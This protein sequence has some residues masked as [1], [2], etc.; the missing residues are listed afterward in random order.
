MLLSLRIYLFFR[1]S[2][3]FKSEMNNASTRSPFWFFANNFLRLSLL[4][5][6]CHAFMKACFLEEWQ[7]SLHILFLDFLS[8]SCFSCSSQ[9]VVTYAAL[10]V[11]YT[12]QSIVSPTPTPTRTRPFVPTPRYGA[13]RPNPHADQDLIPTPTP[14]PSP[15]PT[16]GFVEH[17]GSEFPIVPPSMDRCTSNRK[18]CKT[19]ESVMAIWYKMSEWKLRS[20]IVDSFA[21][22]I[23]CLTIMLADICFSVA[24]T[25][26]LIQLVNGKVLLSDLMSRI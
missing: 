17:D 22:Y 10:D 6:F 18:H 13:D 1:E 8:L 12:V 7:I 15:T 14:S 19:C 11:W 24:M 4:C 9:G 20:Y 26:F 16:V 2:G 23:Y 5:F 25:N 3:H 21:S